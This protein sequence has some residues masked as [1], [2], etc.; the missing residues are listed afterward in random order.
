MGVATKT[1]RGSWLHEATQERSRR[2]ERSL[3][4][5]ALRLLAKRPFEEITVA[6]IAA[7]AGVSVGG[8]Y[9]RF[10]NKR[11]VLNL[12]EGDFL[13][14]CLHAFDVVMSDEALAGETLEVV[15]R[16]YIG[17]MV[18]M[19]RQYRGAI[20]QVMRN[21]DPADAASFQERRR[22]FNEH[23]HGR[24]RDLLW[25]RREVINHPDPQAAI[26]MAIFFASSAARDAIWRNSLA[27]HGVE[28]NDAELIEE[29][30]RGFV[31][32]LRV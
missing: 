3:H 15:A 9:R 27:E 28:L 5:A 26:S 21:A 30:V 22:A 11:A 19:F 6:D 13:E 4:L 24:F 10:R 23:V 8:F 29:L 14:D 25:E 2:T 16:T 31:A 1:E 7:E 12:A 18:R 17:V 32:Y 20:L